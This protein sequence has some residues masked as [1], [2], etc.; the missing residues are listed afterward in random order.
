[1]K[2]KVGQPIL[3]W[4]IGRT[5]CRW[6]HNIGFSTHNANIVLYSYSFK[7]WNM[8][9]WWHKIMHNWYNLRPLK[10]LDI[11][12]ISSWLTPRSNLVFKNIITPKQIIIFASWYCRVIIQ[13]WFQGFFCPQAI[14]LFWTKPINLQILDFFYSVKASGKNSVFNYWA[15]LKNPLQYFQF[16]SPLCVQVVLNK[17][18]NSA[19]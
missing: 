4:Y 12:P 13:S 15:S 8:R 5:W 10:T 6:W 18:Q 7:I 16:R 19:F 1:M 9:Y 2:Q 3:T 11:Q 17:K 14:E